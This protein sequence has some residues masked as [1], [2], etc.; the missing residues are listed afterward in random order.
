MPIQVNT[1]EDLTQDLVSVSVNDGFW[2]VLSIQWDLTSLP[3]CISTNMRSAARFKSVLISLSFKAQYAEEQPTPERRTYTPKLLLSIRITHVRPPDSV[4]QWGVQVV[5]PLRQTGGPRP[6]AGQIAG[7]EEQRSNPFVSGSRSGLEGWYLCSSI[8]THTNT[9]RCSE[10]KG[11]RAC[12]IQ[13]TA[14]IIF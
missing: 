3:S 2:I 12:T 14:A 8:P 5:C 13:S 9:F 7:Q 6:S 10:C 1:A 11:N 4:C